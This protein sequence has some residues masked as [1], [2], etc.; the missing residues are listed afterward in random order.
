MLLHKT[1]TSC[2][3]EGV[4]MGESPCADC[5]CPVTLEG[6]QGFMGALVMPLLRMHWR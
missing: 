5:V 1:V 6:E 3:L 4:L 2:G